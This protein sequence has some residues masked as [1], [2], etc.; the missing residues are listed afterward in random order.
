MAVCLLPT[1]NFTIVEEPLEGGGAGLGITPLT[2]ILYVA[3]PL[4]LR[5]GKFVVE[6]GSTTTTTTIVN[7]EVLE[8]KDSEL[9][10]R[11]KHKVI[12]TFLFL[13]ILCVCR[14]MY[15]FLHLYVLKVN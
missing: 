8:S 14:I 11:C 9:V 7:L 2:G 13:F 12:S 4:L 6:R 1:G 15:V 10:E 5:S 3:D